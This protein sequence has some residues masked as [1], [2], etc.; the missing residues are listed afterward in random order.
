MIK[1]IQFILCI[2]I[3][4]SCSGTETN[5]P[6]TVNQNPSKIEEPEPMNFSD[7]IPE[8]YPDSLKIH[9]ISQLVDEMRKDTNMVHTE[10]EDT[11]NSRLYAYY[12]NDSLQMISKGYVT[13]YFLMD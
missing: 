11:L 8:N 9:I 1:L 7:I 3:F 4:V 13:Y 2:L 10:I 6:K 5:I 12:R